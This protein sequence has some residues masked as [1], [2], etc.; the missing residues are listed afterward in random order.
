M[1]EFTFLRE[2]DAATDHVAVAQIMK[3]KTEPATT[4][5]MRLL[6]RFLLTVLTCI[7]SKVGI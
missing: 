1:E 7:M 6:G 5:I 4:R 3:T 2:F